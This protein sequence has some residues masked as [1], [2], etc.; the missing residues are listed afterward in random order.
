MPARTI[1]HIMG[2]KISLKTPG[3]LSSIGLWLLFAGLG[4]GLLQLPLIS[5][6]LAGFGAMLLHWFSDLW[7]QLGHAYIARSVGYPMKGLRFHWGLI[8]SIYPHNEPTLPAHIHIKRALGGPIATILLTLV[9]GILMG[10]LTPMGGIINY[11][12]QF[13]FWENLLFFFFGAFLPLGFTDGSTLLKW[14]PRLK[15]EN[16]LS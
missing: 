10:L 5:A 9:A 8:A 14:L 3:I 15:E 4:Y 2:V 7:H 16:R 6:L 1:G 13:F 11:L 12:S